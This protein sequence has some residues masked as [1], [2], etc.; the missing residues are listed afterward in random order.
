MLSFLALLISLEAGVLD[1]NTKVWN[2]RFQTYDAL[3]SVVDLKLRAWDLV[4]LGYNNYQSFMDSPESI[5]YI[6]ITETYTVS[7]SV[8]LNGFEIGALHTCSHPVGYFFDK[9]LFIDDMNYSFNKIFV[10]YEFEYV[11]K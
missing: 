11:L 10:K 4:Y 5:T 7:L 8:K 9:N 1:N 2:G 6:P 3:Y